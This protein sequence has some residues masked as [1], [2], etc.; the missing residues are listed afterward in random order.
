MLTRVKTAPD[1]HLKTHRETCLVQLSH[2]SSSI[3]KKK[4]AVSFC[5]TSIF[6]TLNC[7]RDSPWACRVHE[8]QFVS[9]AT[10]SN[11]TQLNMHQSAN[12]FFQLVAR[13]EFCLLDLC[14]LPLIMCV[15]VFS[16]FV[17]FVQKLSTVTWRWPLVWSGPSSCVSPSRTSLLKVCVCDSLTFC[18][19]RGSRQGLFLSDI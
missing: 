18:V 8:I 14:P 1:W 12:T 11:I 4:T 7:G 10:S 16:V 13:P 3:K 17:W 2:H 5:A 15:F 6:F 9:M 19:I